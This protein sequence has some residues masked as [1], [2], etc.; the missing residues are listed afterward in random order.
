MQEIIEFNPVQ[1]HEKKLAAFRSWQ[2]IALAT[3]LEGLTAILPPIQ[4][5]MSKQKNTETIT[6]TVR[7]EYVTIN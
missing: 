5:T 7:T 2:E 4:L 3:P 1:K 6:C